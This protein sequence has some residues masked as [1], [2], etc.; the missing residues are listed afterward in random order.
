[1]NKIQK[2]VACA[3]LGFGAVF[4]LTGCGYDRNE[5]VEVE[6]ESDENGKEYLEIEVHRS[7]GMD[8]EDTF[9]A[10]VPINSGCEVGDIYNRDTKT[11]S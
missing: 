11:C 9:E 10:D 6:Q 7:G 1:M 8:S 2:T 4:T 5:V 3:A